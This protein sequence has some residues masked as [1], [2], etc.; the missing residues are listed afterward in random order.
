MSVRTPDLLPHQRIVLPVDVSDRNVAEDL[1]RSLSGRIGVFKFGL[2]LITPGLAPLLA[3]YAAS[4]GAGTFWDGK[5]HDIS[6]T[7]AAASRAT[8]RAPVM[9]FNVHATASAKA[10]QAAAEAKGDALLLAVTVLTDIAPEE[11]VEIYGRPPEEMV[12]FLARRAQRNGADGVIC[13]PRELPILNAH[14]DL[15]SLLRVTPGV[16]P[17]WAASDDQAR[18]TTPAEAV[19]L[20]AD[21]VVVGRPI[22]RPPA[23]I[24]GEPGTPV[25]AAETIARE[26]ASALEGSA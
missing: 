13:S 7:V 11:C 1:V 20:G 14:A 24:N 17:R 22:T 16:R 5:L 21:Y 6:N 25:L 10:I 3:G 2:E 18:V 12:P 15:E 4:S 8:L 26:I 19:A 23:S 9:M